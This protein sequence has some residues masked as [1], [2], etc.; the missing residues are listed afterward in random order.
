LAASRKEQT[1]LAVVVRLF[2][3]ELEEIARA[4]GL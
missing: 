3:D 2:D 4:H 1:W